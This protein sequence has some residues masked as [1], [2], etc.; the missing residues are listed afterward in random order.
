[1]IVEDEIR[2]MFRL[3]RFLG[4]VLASIVENKVG[5]RES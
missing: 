1:M 3:D 4:L 5:D 2:E